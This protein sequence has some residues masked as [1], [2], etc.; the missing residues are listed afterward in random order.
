MVGRHEEI[1]ALRA[2]AAEASRGN[3]ALIG[4]T[5]EAGIGKTRLASEAALSLRGT[6]LCLAGRAYA[7]EGRVPFGMWVD[8]LVPALAKRTPEALR[9]LLGTRTI[10]RR[11]FPNLDA[12]IGDSE[13]QLGAF[14]SSE[15]A[16]LMFLVAFRDLLRRLAEERPVVLS[17]DDVHAADQASLELLHF[18]ARGA[19]AERMLVLATYRSTLPVEPGFAACLDSLRRNDSLAEI[20]LRAL[21]EAQTKE[22]VANATGA[23]ASSSAISRLHQRTGGNPFFLQ[24]VVRPGGGGSASLEGLPHSIGALVHE[25]LAHLSE[26]ARALLTLCAVAGESSSL[27]L[28]Q[29]VSALDENGLLGGVEEL[30]RHRFLSERVEGGRLRYAFTHPLF[31]EVVYDELSEARRASFH[32]TIGRTLGDPAFDDGPEPGEL[33]FHLSR[34]LS[35]RTR[36]LALPHL[37]AAAEHALEVCA[38]RDALDYF[39]RALAVLEPADPAARHWAV[40][41]GCGRALVRLGRFDQAIE[42]WQRALSVA[43]DAE[44][45]AGVY[46]RIGSACWNVGDEERAV[47]AFEAGLAALEGAPESVEAA[48]LWQELAAARQRLGQ[49]ERSIDDNLR[50]VAIAE[51]HGRPELAARAFVGLLTNYAVQGNMERGA[52]YGRRAVALAQAPAMAPVAQFAHSTLGALLRHRADHAA[53]TGHLHEALRIADALGAQALE[54]WPLAALSDGARSRGELRDALRYGRQA[55]EIDRAFG[56]NGLLPRSLAFAALA[57]DMLG[58]ADLARELVAEALDLLQTLRKHEIRIWTVVYGAEARS[59]FVRGEFELAGE[60]GQALLDQLALRGWPA[61][62]VLAPLALPLRVESAIRAGSFAVAR[63]GL[64]Q[65]REL[66]ARCASPPAEA[67]HS[68]LRALLDA[69]E[70]RA[71]VTAFDDCLARYEVLGLSPPLGHA[72]LD[73]GRLLSARG[74]RADALAAFA[75]GRAVA[76]AMEYAPLLEA[77]VAAERAA[78]HKGAAARRPSGPLTERELQVA[79][80]AANGLTNR[81]IATELHISL[82]TAETH[83][84]NALRKSGVRSRSELRAGMR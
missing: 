60:R 31:R 43:P 17:L 79:G 62:Y 36:R 27:S 3:G 50:S 28:L 38:Q 7:T 34:S 14:D 41:E 18:V 54:S 2:A 52:E 56:Q 40:L 39:E 57:H 72:L 66:A 16:K 37:L 26:S 22:F 24:H 6:F 9:R 69:E 63:A 33:A 58:E 55:V 48:L 80:L 77:F 44:R 74:D 12:S 45:R 59:A 21:D 35:A 46:R 67:A 51:R 81:Q 42:I 5:G 76:E 65:L 4:I 70:G 19:A 25:R 8:A 32:E 82:L 13:L 73:K 53:S 20:D 71:T 11:V 64:E 84:R 83:V 61:L 49:P 29:R 30:L 15:H 10:L 47:G 78:G 23:Y 1:L 68:H 75:R